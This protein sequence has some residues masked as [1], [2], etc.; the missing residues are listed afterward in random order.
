MTRNENESNGYTLEEG[1][2]LIFKQPEFAFKIEI[3]GFMF[4]L[5]DDFITPFN[6]GSKERLFILP[7]LKEKN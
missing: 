6:V 3:D 1:L 7:P 5:V 4:W 2:D